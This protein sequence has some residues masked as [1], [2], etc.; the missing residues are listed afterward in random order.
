M[1]GSLVHQIAKGSYVP[2]HYTVAWSG[3]EGS[4]GSSIYVVQMK[5]KNFDK[6][7]KLIKVE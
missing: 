1:K 7:I 5:A 2:G 3:V 6:R 4:L